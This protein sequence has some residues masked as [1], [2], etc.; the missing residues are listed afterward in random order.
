MGEQLMERRENWH[1][2]QHS[3]NVVK[4]EVLS[5]QTADLYDKHEV[6]RALLNEIKVCMESMSS[7]MQNGFMRQELSIS[8]LTKAFEQR[9]E[10]SDGVLAKYEGVVADFHRKFREY[11]QFEWFRS[12]VT[13]V[14]DNFLWFG[15]GL[16]LIGITALVIFHSTSEAFVRLLGKL[17]GIK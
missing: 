17:A 16:L 3:G 10:Y 11:D 15:M 9:V 2:E 14:R 13:W 1:C 7:N 12:K 5:D 6:T 8:N 4:I